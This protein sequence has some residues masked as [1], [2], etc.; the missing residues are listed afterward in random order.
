LS[1]I[2][3]VIAWI[4]IVL[5]AL[6][7]P[8]SVVSVWAINLTTNT[9]KYVETMAPLARN[10]VITDHIAV[11]ATDKLFEVIPVQEKLDSS[12]PKRAAFIAPAITQELH[13]FVQKQLTT[14]LSSTWFHQLWDKINRRTHATM[15]AVL[16]GKPNPRVKKASGIVLD[17]TPVLEKGIAKLDARGITIFDGAKE[18]LTKAN[19]LSLDLANGK[20]VAK[21]RSLFRVLSDLGW[22]V[23]LGTLLI[24]VVA[25]AVAVD[26]R[27]TLLRVFVG[28]ALVTVLILSGVLIGRDFFASHEAKTIDPAV[29]Q[30]VFQTVLRFL[31]HWLR[32]ELLISLLLAVALWLVGPASWARWI[33]A[34]VIR[35]AR[36]LVQQGKELTGPE[37]HQQSSKGAPAAAWVFGHRSGLRITGLAVAGVIIIFGG[38]LSVS[39]VWF[40]AL[41]LVIYLIVLQVVIVWARRRALHDEAST[42]RA[43]S[44][45]PV[46]S[47]KGSPRT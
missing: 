29:S 5:S 6:L 37:R 11:R 20:Q 25:G 21:A 3:G 17:V 18:K 41:G 28:A 15:V 16:T 36:W 9:D 35:A 40:T 12:L 44:E 23:P 2:R 8:L 30:A 22:A 27:K 34:H 46:Q 31:T 42:Q 39:G 19:T 4:L 47:G 24:V 10:R 38:N 13:S 32:V 45:I 14:L 43:T 33:R 1:R 26:R 7:I